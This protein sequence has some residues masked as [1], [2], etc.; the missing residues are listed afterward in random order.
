MNKV[1]KSFNSSQ[2]FGSGLALILIFLLIYLFNEK[3]LYLHVAIFL[4]IVLMVWPA[5]FR[6]F[7]IMWFAFAEITGFI[8]SR[9]LL[10]FIFLLIVVPAGFIK[11]KTLHRNLWLGQFWKSNNSVFITRNHIFV[12][13]DLLKPF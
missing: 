1:K 7:A 8:V 12:A 2:L 5:P 9:I 10:T 11:R 6:F 4:T 3:R 13:E